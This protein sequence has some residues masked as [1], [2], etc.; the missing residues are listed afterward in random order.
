MAWTNRGHNTTAARLRILE[1]DGY[2]CV[3]CGDA[4]GPFEVDHIDNTRGPNY[5]TDA[6]KQT[7][8]V[9]CHE[10]KTRAEARRGHQRYYARRRLPQKPHPGLIG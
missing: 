10:K 9:T 3:H 7:L 4:Q 1:R 6:N 8:C 2:R 5:N